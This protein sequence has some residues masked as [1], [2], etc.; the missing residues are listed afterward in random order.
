MKTIAAMLAST[1]LVSGAYA[2]APARPAGAASAAD[3][4][5]AD[6]RRSSAVE[7][8][9]RDMHAKL[10]IT[11]AQESQWTTVAQTMR[12]SAR[13]LDA[14]IDKRGA[15]VGSATAPENLSAYGDIAQA[16]ADGVKKLAAAFTPLYASMPDE[17]KKLADDVFARR[18]HKHRK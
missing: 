13:E 17:Q 3:A 4:A 5:T 12:D 9:I 7:Q 11:A 8:H 18:A 16:H 1:I 2:Q 14:A 10:G 6:T 15:I